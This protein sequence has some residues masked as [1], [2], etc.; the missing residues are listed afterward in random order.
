MCTSPHLLISF[1]PPNQEANDIPILSGLERFHSTMLELNFSRNRVESLALFATH[2]F[3]NLTKL[4][5]RENYL[6]T[7]TQFHY[8]HYCPQLTWVDFAENAEDMDLMDTLAELWDE[9]GEKHGPWIAFLDGADLEREKHQEAGALR[10]KR[11]QE[12][13]VKEMVEQAAEEVRRRASVAEG[14]QHK[15]EVVAEEL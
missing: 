10:R 6:V 8:L 12:K 2:P 7:R 4:N 3:P 5:A 13:L 11:Y 1:L 9:A 15:V 14:L